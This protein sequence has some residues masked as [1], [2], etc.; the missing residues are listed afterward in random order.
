M[1]NVSFTVVNDRIS[2]VLNALV[3]LA[4]DPTPMLRAMGTTFLSITQGNFHTETFRARAWVAKK[5]GT[6]ATLMKSNLLWR[7]I[8]LRLE[9]HSAIV[10]APVPYAAIH[11]FGARGHQ[12][13]SKTGTVLTRA[14]RLRQAQS[15]DV[16]SGGKGIPPRPF[17]PV[18]NNR[19]TF[20]AEKRILA[21]GARAVARTSNP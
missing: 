18:V 6:P 3:L 13:G 11:Q 15:Q 7:S 12:G 10:S 20:E 14:T 21:A 16:T 17:Y 2:P 4:R 5:D 19:L 1:A 9:Q 8:N